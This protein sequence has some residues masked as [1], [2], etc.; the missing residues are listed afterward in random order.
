MLVDRCWGCACVLTFS[1][2]S[3]VR[4]KTLLLVLFLLGVYS[5]GAQKKYVGPP[6]QVGRE[7][8]NPKMPWMVS[9]LSGDNKERLKRVN[10][11]SKH[12]V[13]GKVLCFRRLCRIQVGHDAPMK[14]ISYER[15]KKK[16]AR[17]AKKGEYKN[18][19]VDTTR[20]RKP[21][22]QKV[23]PV[24]VDTAQTQP[25]AIESIQAKADTLIVLGAELLFETNKST[26][27]SEHFAA[28]NPIV[29]YLLAH[30]ERTVKISGHTDNTGRESHNQNLSKQRADEVAEYLVGNG[31]SIK[32]IETSGLGSSKP[33]TDNT[34]EAGR[35]KNRRVELLI[36]SGG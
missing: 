21:P 24:A 32:S 14:R 25:V 13:F 7:Y 27:R 10:K 4:M 8:G 18:I 15:F 20:T 11:N 26:L 33:M 17:N 3:P 1:L 16:I 19:R 30:P 23:I 34:T 35:K 9:H 28:L 2:P 12:S 29:D 6:N 36:S 22:L 5:A 31:V